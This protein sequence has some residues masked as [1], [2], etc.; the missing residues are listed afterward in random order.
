LALLYI[1]FNMQRQL[2]GGSTNTMV[3]SGDN[4]Q[5]F[6]AQQQQNPQQ[7]Q[8]NQAMFNNFQQP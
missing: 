2:S 6:V 3:G 5:N 8:A 7:Q 1:G 4:T